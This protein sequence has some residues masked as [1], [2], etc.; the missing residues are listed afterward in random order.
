MD[1]DVLFQSESLDGMRVA[2]VSSLTHFDGSP[3][4]QIDLYISDSLGSEETHYLPTLE[5]AKNLAKELTHL[6]NKAG[7]PGTGHKGFLSKVEKRAIWR[8]ASIQSNASVWWEARIS[9]QVAL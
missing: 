8:R 7:V 5:E 6:G 2:V 4:F 9:R 3:E 1:S